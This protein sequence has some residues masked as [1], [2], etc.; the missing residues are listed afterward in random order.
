MPALRTR[1]P[2]PLSGE[3]REG[4][5]PSRSSPGIPGRGRILRSES[6]DMV[7]QELWGYLL[8]HYAISA[9]ICTAA[10]TPSLPSGSPTR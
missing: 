8:A 4:T 1:F 9:L 7:K 2:I 10:T 3:W 6:P 5:S